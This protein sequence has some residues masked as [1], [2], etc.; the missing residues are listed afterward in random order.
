MLSLH[1]IRFVGRPSSIS[2]HFKPQHN[3]SVRAHLHNPEASLL[4][5]AP[6]PLEQEA[7]WVQSC[8][9]CPE[10]QNS[11]FP[12]SETKHAAVHLVSYSP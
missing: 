1:A 4:D 5:T 6:A 7:G 2:T 10:E 9:A 3:M 11:V 12:L 8:S